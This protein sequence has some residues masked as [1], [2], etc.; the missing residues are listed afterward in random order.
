MIVTVTNQKSERQVQLLFSIYNAVQLHKYKKNMKYIVDLCL[1]NQ[2]TAA[3]MANVTHEF[4]RRCVLA[5]KL[6]NIVR[7]FM[8]IILLCTTIPS[9]ADMFA[10]IMFYIFWTDNFLDYCI[11]KERLRTIEFYR[12]QIE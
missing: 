5:I 12:N 3:K 2:E 10:E 9:V 7:I 8:V 1:D 11:G 4:T 6:G